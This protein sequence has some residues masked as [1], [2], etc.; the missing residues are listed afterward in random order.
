MITF[1]GNLD[2]YDEDG[3]WKPEFVSFQIDPPTLT[4]ISPIRLS[5]SS[6]VSVTLNGVLI[7]F[8]DYQVV[9]DRIIF[10]S[11]LPIHLAGADLNILNS[12]LIVDVNLTFRSSPDVTVSIDE[13]LKTV[14]NNN[15]TDGDPRGVRSAFELALEI[16]SPPHLSEELDMKIKSHVAD[17][18]NALMPPDE[19]QLSGIKLSKALVEHLA[20]TDDFSTFEI[21]YHIPTGPDKGK[22]LRMKIQFNGFVE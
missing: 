3:T 14:F 5:N 20:E 9:G 22:Y 8:S 18:L 11:T 7:D 6:D 1:T 21:N 19:H 12:L 4:I 17:V 15:L 16:F 2:Y 13:R 10:N